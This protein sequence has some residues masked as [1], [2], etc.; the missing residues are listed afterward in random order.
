MGWYFPIKRGAIPVLLD[1]HVPKL[2]GV[3]PYIEP[4]T[5][6]KRNDL[7]YSNPIIS[8]FKSFSQRPGIS[9]NTQTYR[10]TDRYL[11]TYKS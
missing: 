3:S 9:R 4:I 8:H 7:I 1:Q 5:V 11:L 10:Q 6:P 2:E